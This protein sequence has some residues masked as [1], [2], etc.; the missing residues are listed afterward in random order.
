MCHFPHFPLSSLIRW[1]PLASRRSEAVSHTLTHT[2]DR[3]HTRA[4][5]PTPTRSEAVPTY[6]QYIFFLL[7]LLLLLL[8]FYDFC[9]NNCH[10]VCSG[11]TR[12]TTTIKINRKKGEQKKEERKRISNVLCYFCNPFS[13][14]I[15]NCEQF[16]ADYY[17][18]YYCDCSAY[19]LPISFSLSVSLFSHC[20]SRPARPAIKNSNNN[21]MFS[22]FFFVCL[23]VTAQQNNVNKQLSRLLVNISVKCRYKCNL[24]SHYLL[25]LPVSLSRL[26]SSLR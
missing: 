8:L 23:E 3:W 16:Y 12:T 22:H 26:Y 7:F 11:L 14:F 18:Y 10:A 1:L 21:K 6:L 17:F 20:R 2:R 24:F 9:P 19:F 15:R 13:I 25:S 5:L 4:A